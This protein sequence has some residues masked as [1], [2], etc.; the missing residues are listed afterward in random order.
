[1]VDITYEE[2]TS[3][4]RPKV[5]GAWNLHIAFLGAK[6]PLDFFLMTSSIVTIFEQPG[7]SN[8]VAANTFLE[9]F[10]QYRRAWASQ[11][12]RWVSVP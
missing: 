8:Y 3:V 11:P 10:C 4:I 5:E 12:L 6:Q 9:A 7:Q 2:W 1:M